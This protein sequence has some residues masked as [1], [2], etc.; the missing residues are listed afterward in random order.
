MKKILF[1]MLL[2]TLGLAYNSKA[3][4][5]YRVDDAAIETTLSLAT[6]VAQTLVDAAQLLNPMSVQASSSDK[7]VWIAAVLD[8]F[9]GGFAIHRVYLGTKPIMILW[10]VITV[11]GIFGIV[12]LIDLIVLIIDNQD[13]SK[14]VGS[15]KF[16]MW[17]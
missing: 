13:I 2:C 9:L 17:G 14:Y 3:T 16:F 4:S 6:P 1:L 10:Y 12:P 7:N 15:N 5:I 8:F 11:G